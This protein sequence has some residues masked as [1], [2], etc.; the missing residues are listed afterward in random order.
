MVWSR[1]G[2]SAVFYKQECCLPWDM[3][4]L[5]PHCFLRDEALSVTNSFFLPHIDFVL[6]NFPIEMLSLK[7]VCALQTAANNSHGCEKFYVVSHTV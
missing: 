2:T 5:H 1:R 6:V 3:C 7:S 4:F